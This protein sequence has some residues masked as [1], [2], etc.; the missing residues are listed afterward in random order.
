MTTII[1]QSSSYGLYLKELNHSHT[2][3]D[4]DANHATN[5]LCRQGPSVLSEPLVYQCVEPVLGRYVYVRLLG[6]QAL[7]LCEVQV[8]VSRKFSMLIPFS[9][10]V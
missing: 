2:G 4:S 9:Q 10:L 7:I 8:Y 3:D 5:K 1:I 6:K